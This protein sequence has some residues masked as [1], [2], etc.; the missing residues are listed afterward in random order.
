MK[1]TLSTESQLSVSEDTDSCTRERRLPQTSSAPSIESSSIT[2]T[3]AE[4][5][6]QRTQQ[7]QK[8][9]LGAGVNEILL[10]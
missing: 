5:K 3:A 2:E 1:E 8:S 7:S 6:R 10:S 9:M 4:K